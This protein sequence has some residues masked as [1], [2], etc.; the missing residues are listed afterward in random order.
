MQ[1]GKLALQ[2]VTQTSQLVVLNKTILPR[3]LEE[4]STQFTKLCYIFCVNSFTSQS[5]NSFSN[6]NNSLQKNCIFTNSMS[7]IIHIKNMVCPRCVTAVEQTLTGLN[8]PYAHV[9][10]GVANLDKKLT[11][12][13]LKKLDEEL[14]KIG[15]ELIQDK[16]YQLI[17]KVKTIIVDH[18]HHHKA[19]ELKINYSEYLSQKTGKE[20]SGL[21]KLFSDIENTTIEKYIILQKIEKVK[22]LISYGELNFSQIA[23]ETN[24][25]SV[26]HLSKQFKKITGH[27]LSDYKKLGENQRTTIDK[28]K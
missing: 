19:Q 1:A 17:E 5:V 15:F 28:V 12:D 14:K 6:R 3:I 20:Y 9:E 13:E 7:K 4:Y 16:N 21:S 23:F 8:I 22:E 24:Y 26:A 25:S 2:F 27:T 10:L 18:I 11:Q